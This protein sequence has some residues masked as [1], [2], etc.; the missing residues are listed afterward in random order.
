MLPTSMTRIAGLI[1][2]SVAMPSARPS[3]ATM[4]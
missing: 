4:A 1:S 3:D 2:I